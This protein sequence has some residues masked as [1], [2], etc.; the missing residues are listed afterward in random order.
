MLRCRQREGQGLDPGKRLVNFP[1]VLIAPSR[2][3]G[4]YNNSAATTALV[5]NCSPRSPARLI[6]EVDTWPGPKAGRS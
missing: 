3:F 6:F 4:A 1:A 5:T 2:A